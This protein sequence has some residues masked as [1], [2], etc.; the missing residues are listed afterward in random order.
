MDSFPLLLSSR[1]LVLGLADFVVG[2]GVGLVAWCM[3]GPA[4]PVPTVDTYSYCRC[5]CR[6][7]C[8]PVCVD[9][10]CYLVLSVCPSLFCL[11]EP[12]HP[13]IL[14]FGS[15]AGC[16]S[17][18]FFLTTRL[19]FLSVCVRAGCCLLCMQACPDFWSSSSRVCMFV[20]LRALSVGCVYSVS[21]TIR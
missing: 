13:S 15:P 16:S 19:G 3:V 6:R 17:G 2:L 14:V 11:I 4:A 20:W 5:C 7:R 21:C 10:A 9:D 12:M 1:R 8:L 18:G